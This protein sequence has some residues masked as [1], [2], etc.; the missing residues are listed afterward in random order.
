[1]GGGGRKAIYQRWGVVDD[2]KGGE[3]GGSTTTE[4]TAEFQNVMISN[5]TPSGEEEEDGGGRGGQCQWC[6]V[7]IIHRANCIETRA[8]PD[9]GTLVGSVFE[10]G[11]GGRVKVS[12]KPG[13]NY[14]TTVAAC[15]TRSTSGCSKECVSVL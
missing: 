10:G 11:G 9:G 7:F 1:M 2:L 15:V 6:P 14:P 13:L 8:L 4:I 5:I 12:S 3:G